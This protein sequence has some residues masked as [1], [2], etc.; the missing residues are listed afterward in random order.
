MQIYL[1]F[2]EREYL[3]PKVKGRTNRVKNQIIIWIFPRCSLPSAII[4]AK[5]TNNRVKMQKYFWFYF[6]PRSTFRIFAR[7]FIKSKNLT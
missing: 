3:R 1:Q 2:S 6:V 4:I 5:G 7:K